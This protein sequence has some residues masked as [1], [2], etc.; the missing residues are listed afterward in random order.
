M[1]LHYL[2]HE[3]FRG[4][5]A[6]ERWAAQK[7]FAITAT[8]F[9]KG[10]LLPPLDQVDW[11]VVMGGSMSVNDENEYQWLAPE[12]QFVK[13][14][15]EAGKV[16]VGVCFGAQL[17]ANVLGAKVYPN[18]EK[19]IGWFPI[20]W[21]QASLKTM[22]FQSLS[23]PMNVLHWHGETFDLPPCALRIA[24][25]VGC[26]NQGFLYR[27]KVLALQFHLEFVDG[28]TEYML[29]TFKEGMPKGPYVQTQ[30]E[31]ASNEIL[32]PSSN[33]ALYGILNALHTL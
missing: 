33:D 22:L 5:G 2:Q 30:K 24:R 25:S 7:G 26:L 32:I 6:I 18:S 1:R 31:I 17:L 3:A 29:S 23:S 13:Q 21:E 11:V 16:V 15:I 4:P 14:A 27:E 12:K 10:D 19:E 9:H 8:H 28:S 20:T